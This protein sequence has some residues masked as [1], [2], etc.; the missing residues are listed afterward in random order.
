MEGWST[1]IEMDDC[2]FFL[3]VDESGEEEWVVDE[4]DGMNEMNE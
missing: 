2:I 1:N 3:S 4:E